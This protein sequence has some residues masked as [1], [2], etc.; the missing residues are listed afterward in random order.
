MKSE[1]EIMAEYLLKGGKMLSATCPSC[2]CPL[3]EI[4]GQT[5]CVVCREAEKRDEPAGIRGEQPDPERVMVLVNA[6]KRGIEA[7]RLL[8]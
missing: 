3:F 4:D 8:G 6:L 7:L 5:L 2:G 1:D